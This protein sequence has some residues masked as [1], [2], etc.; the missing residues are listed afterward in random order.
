VFEALPECLGGPV[1]VSRVFAGKAQV[2][3]GLG[4]RTVRSHRLLQE[5]HG[6]ERVFGQ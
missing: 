1:Q 6:T 4:E 5:L 3:P 2:Y